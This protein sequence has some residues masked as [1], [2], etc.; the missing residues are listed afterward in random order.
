MQWIC[1]WVAALLIGAE[2]GWHLGIVA[3]LGFSA[4]LFALDK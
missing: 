3:W 2:F 1:A 4:I